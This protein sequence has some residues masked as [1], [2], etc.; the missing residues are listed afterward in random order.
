MNEV[1][2][3]MCDGTSDNQTLEHP[4]IYIQLKPNS[5]VVCSYCGKEFGYEQTNT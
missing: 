2:T 4:R 3:V 5:T 1:Q